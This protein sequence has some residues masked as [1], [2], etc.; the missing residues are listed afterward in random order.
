MRRF[1]QAIGGIL[2]WRFFSGLFPSVIHEAKTNSILAWLLLAALAAPSLFAADTEL[3]NYKSGIDLNFGDSATTAADKGV[4][5]AEEYFYFDKVIQD[6]KVVYIKDDTLISMSQN[7]RNVAA[8]SGANSYSTVGPGFGTIKWK[9][10]GDQSRRGYPADW[11]AY[12]TPLAFDDMNYGYFGA[13]ETAVVGTT[14]ATGGD[15]TEANRVNRYY[16][17][18]LDSVGDEWHILTVADDDAA[19]GGHAEWQSSDGK[20]W[21]FVVN[22]KTPCATW[23]VSGSGQ[24]YTTPPKKY[25]F[26]IIYDQTTYFS[27]TVTCEL[28]DIN[29]NNVFY[30]INGGS[31][32][33]A[34]ANKVTLDQDDF[35][36]GSNT[37]EYY[38]A[39]NAAHTKTRTV[40][41]NPAY[42][43]AGEAH[44]DRLWVSAALWESE[45]KPRITAD[46]ELTKWRNFFRTNNTW[47]SQSTIT[48]KSRT[49]VRTVADTA[50][51]N[52]FTAR[53]EGMTYKQSGYTH[54]AA[55]LARLALFDTKALLDPIGYEAASW[56]GIPIP[57]REMNYRGYYDVPGIY[58]AAAAYDVLIGYYRADQGHAN[59]ITAVQDFFIR[60]ALARWVHNSHLII[61]GY[62]GGGMWPTA[63]VTGAGVIAGV[64]PAYSTEYFGTCGLD[65]NTTT[66]DWTPFPAG[67]ANYTWKDI[68]LTTSVP[69]NGYP[70]QARRA[71]P[72]EHFS[73]D[74]KWGDRISYTDTNLFGRCVQ[75]HYNMVELFYP[76][77]I[78]PTL[79]S[80]MNKAAQGQLDGSKVITDTDGGAVFRAWIGLQNAW[81]P[82]FRSIAR[83]AMLSLAW[84]HSDSIG[85]QVQ[86]GGVFSI[87]YYNHT[88]L[89]PTQTKG[90]KIVSPLREP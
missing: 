21:L 88:L 64:M 19:L 40:V 84:P 39:G 2:T 26:P 4:A 58:E 28:R 46:A 81:F 69:V 50:F 77:T 55:D 5:Y 17:G 66:H 85:K 1:Q 35:N 54:T 24:F 51:V 59:G 44:G 82:E 63:H 45:V 11:T 31:F 67:S 47:N 52:A 80:A 13:S 49:G 68:F 27:G 32:T 25:F 36:T 3:T 62:A 16:R 23:R 86:N 6:S 9:V 34:G 42:P 43:S 76:E 74:G 83:P 79:D 14:G 71:T 60:D 75:M 22:P 53:W 8:Q 41:K 48:T 87:L 72:A 12:T 7:A 29:G 90:L 30:R 65:G 37:L 89:L 61:A 57:S 33:N 70:E 18:M 38:Y 10:D 73:V 15:L 20:I 56:S 78:Y